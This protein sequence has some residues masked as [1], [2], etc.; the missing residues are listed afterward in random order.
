MRR[1]AVYE[2]LN[3]SE[4]ER[5]YAFIE[6]CPKP[7]MQKKLDE[8]SPTYSS[9]LIALL[10][11]LV[12][13][14]ASRLKAENQASRTSNHLCCQKSRKL[15]NRAS[16]KDLNRRDKIETCHVAPS[17]E[18]PRRIERPRARGQIVFDQWSLSKQR[19]SGSFSW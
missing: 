13:R 6:A 1:R 3:D 9:P 11:S 12:D 5:Y 14:Y 17:L 19:S 18:N 2:S 15:V 10:S 4:R 16:Q 8:V 7:K